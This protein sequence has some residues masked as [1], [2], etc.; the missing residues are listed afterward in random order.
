MIEL[1]ITVAVIAILAAIA[2][3]A[4]TSYINRSYLSEISSS[5]AALKSAEESSLTLLG[6]Y[7]NT[8][9]NPSTIPQNGRGTTWANNS[10]AWNALLPN[11]RLD[12]AVRFQYQVY[13][14][15]SYNAGAC[16]AGDSLSSTMDQT[17]GCV[18]PRTAL[19]PSTIYGSASNWY[20]LVARGDL[21]GDGVASNIVSAVDDSSIIYCN[22][23]E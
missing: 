21:D 7:I 10:A 6:C 3:P 22:E 5:F 1:M 18:N 16:A 8:G 17:F 20:V 9:A 23:L 4:Y 15:N 11:T 19:I 14:T 2:I 13:A 12:R